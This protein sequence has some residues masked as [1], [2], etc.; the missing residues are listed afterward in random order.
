MIFNLSFH[1]GIDPDDEAVVVRLRVVVALEDQRRNVR[2][3]VDARRLAATKRS[4]N[5]VWQL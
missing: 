1:T 5:D 3:S 2:V 4:Q